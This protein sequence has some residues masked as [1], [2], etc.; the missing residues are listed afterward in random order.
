MD[1]IIEVWRKIIGFDGQYEI[2]NLGNVRS[3]NKLST[4]GRFFKGKKLAVYNSGSYL[5]VSTLRKPVHRL[6]AESFIPNPENKPC[7]NHKNGIKT[8]N[9]IE[10]LEWCTYSENVIHAY[11]T[12]LMKRGSD[13]ANSKI[14]QIDATRMRKMKEQDLSTNT[15]I[16]FFEVSKDIV[17]SVLSKR[18]WNG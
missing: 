11:Q 15:I 8:D 12:G 4:D 2:S 16:W 1:S 14:N 3:N 7:I 17:Y 5:R 10:N 9:R 13:N 6:I 18:S